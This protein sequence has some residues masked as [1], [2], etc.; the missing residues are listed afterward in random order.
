MADNQL[1]PFYNLKAVVRQTGIK[2]DTLRAWERR[3][4]LPMPGRSA[5]GHR[6]FS[7]RDISVIKWL[8]A[9]QR[10][11]LSISRAVDL[12]QQVVS[13]GQDPLR[14]AAPLASA[15]PP[16]L[17]TIE[18]R[19]ALAKLRAD[20]FSSCLQYDEQKADQI[21]S[22]AFA[23]YPPE[24]VALGLI[25]KAVAEAGEG[26][27]RGEVTVQQEHFCSAL[28]VR[29]LEAMVM[30]AP[31]P[32]RPGRIL[33]ACPPQERHVISLLL[34]TYLL[35]RRGWGVVYLG[36]D[37]PVERL[38][39]TIGL[40]EPQLVILAAQQLH[41]TASLLEM[42]EVLRG[43]N[44]PLAFGGL[45]FNTLPALRPR[46]PGHFLGESLEMAPQMVDSLI[47]LPR[48]VPLT[49][50]D[51]PGRSGRSRG[52]EHALDRLHIA[53]D[54]FLERQGLIEGEMTRLANEGEL[55]R[56]SLDEINTDLGRDISA[57]L[58][59]GDMAFL[60]ANLRWVEG[61]MDNR[62]MPGTL[63]EE[64]LGAYLRAASSSLDERGKPILA[65]LSKRMENRKHV[66]RTE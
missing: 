26:W 2:A 49:H 52:S 6:L 66:S 3:Y 51:A 48:S 57:A 18:G 62:Q 12:W 17:V 23:L 36:A 32:A 45:I 63:L 28:A 42:A 46:I 38:E 15:G 43:K 9:R 56:A 59:L 4:G 44:V 24:A 25:Q 65:W 8:M 41:A 21:L 31:P 11:G 39:A 14:T 30:S 19:N 1:G 54:H 27:Y 47:T 29:R 35:R 58:A 16:I 20:W 13:E 60:D 61:L 22:Q 34:L 10:E 53:R 7:Q 5:G 37:V 33:A 40:A 50:P 55:K 64:Y